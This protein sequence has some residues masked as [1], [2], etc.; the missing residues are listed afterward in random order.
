[1]NASQIGMLKSIGLMLKIVGEPFWCAVADVTNRQKIL[2][3][4]CILMQVITLETLRWV[5]LDF[6]ILILVKILRTTTAPIGTLTTTACFALTKGSK[7]G[8]GKQR[9]FG[10]LAWG[11]G[12]F[13]VG[14]FADW[15]G[16]NSIFLFTY[17]F[18]LMSL[19]LFVLGIPERLFRREKMSESDSASGCG[20]VNDGDADGQQ[21]IHGPLSSFSPL[22]N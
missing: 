20:W 22:N 8:Y 10:A 11:A 14:Y 9:M 7:E 4:L 21:S 16:M 13:L 2:F 12:A 15:F 17:F 6:K 18:N 1:M 19:L 5:S 3:A